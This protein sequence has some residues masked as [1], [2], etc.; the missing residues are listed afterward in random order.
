MLAS[1]GQNKAQVL[2]DKVAKEKQQNK[3][4]KG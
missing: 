1:A 2:P 4:V 3:N